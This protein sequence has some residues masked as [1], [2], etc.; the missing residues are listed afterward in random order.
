MSSSANRNSSKSGVPYGSATYWENRYRN[1][2]DAGFE[3]YPNADN[4][5][6]D[7]LPDAVP[8]CGSVLEIGSGSSQMARKLLDS[9]RRVW[10]TDISP[11]V[12]SNMRERGL[13]DVSGQVEFSVI[14]CCRLPFRPASFDAVVDKATLDAID[15]T[16][17]RNT[18]LCLGEVHRVLRG[19]GVY[20]LISCRE[21]T[22]READL[23]GLFTISSVVDVWSESDPHSPCPLAHVY[24]CV[25]IPTKN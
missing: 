12:C 13:S 7:A 11:T 25:P 23:G 21:P 3:W 14:D 24:T 8:A 16:D 22:V 9:S 6:A 2:S 10:F 19:C 17:D 5:V 18:N 15:C 20:F 1:E 4:V